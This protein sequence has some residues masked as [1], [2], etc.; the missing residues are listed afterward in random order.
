MKT[1]SDTSQVQLREPS[2]GQPHTPQASPSCQVIREDE[3]IR[4]YVS[5]PGVTREALSVSLQDNL[6]VVTGKRHFKTPGDW[7]CHRSSSQPG[8]YQLKLRLRPDLDPAS[9][10]AELAEGILTLSLSQRESARARQIAVN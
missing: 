2:H 7:T 10:Q 5:L 6:L 9:I 3:G 8:G 4:L 1:T